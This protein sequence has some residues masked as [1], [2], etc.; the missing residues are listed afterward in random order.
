MTEFGSSPPLYSSAISDGRS[1]LKP[2]SPTTRKRPAS[3]PRSGARCVP[4]VTGTAPG[5]HRSSLFPPLGPKKNVYR[6]ALASAV[7][8]CS[9]SGRGTTSCVRLRGSNS[10][11]SARHSAGIPATSVM[12]HGTARTVAD[13]SQPRD[14]QVRYEPPRPAVARN[15]QVAC[16][17]ALRSPL[18]TR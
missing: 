4:T 2:C 15:R 12:A 11:S 1:T 13:W 16:H 18:P 8:P 10:M 17:A 5:I 6:P 9:S 3:R 14:P 7:A